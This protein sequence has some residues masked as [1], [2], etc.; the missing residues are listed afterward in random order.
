MNDLT[1]PLVLVQS[2]PLDYDAR[3]VPLA[4]WISANL[5]DEECMSA[6]P[7]MLAGETVGIGGGAFAYAEVKLVPQPLPMSRFDL[8]RYIN[9]ESGTYNGLHWFEVRNMVA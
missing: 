3:I 1:G 2:E 9:G 5:H 8:T 7:A 4:D 6:V